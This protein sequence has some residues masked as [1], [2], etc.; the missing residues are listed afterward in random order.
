MRLLLISGSL[1]D[2]STNTAALRTL[3]DVAP[4]GVETTLY[5][6]M[7]ALPHFNPD[8]DRQ[9]EPVHPAVAGLRAAVADAEALV[10]STPEYAGALPGALKN[11]LEWT[12]GDA[13]TYRKPVGWLNVAGPAAPTGAADAHASLAKV[14]AYVGA[15]VV[16][17]ACVRIPLT[18][19]QVGADGRIGDD[20]VRA[21]LGAAVAALEARAAAGPDEASEAHRG[22]AGAPVDQRAAVEFAAAWERAWNAH[23]LDAL[24]RHFAEDVVFTSPV[25]AQLLPGSDGVIRGREAL[26]AYWAHALGLLPELHFTVEAVY[27]GLETVVINYRNHAGNRVCEVLR[28]DGPLVVAGQATYLSDAAAAAS[29]LPAAAA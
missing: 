14:L 9:G 3:R 5:D 19:A 20:G 29:G 27:T 28:F 23:D 4:P 16:D 7:A 1:R 11:L 25:A 18:R 2:G 12:V 6:G 22:R 15:D 17:A 10:I 24:L 21:A 13:G 26:R 8:D